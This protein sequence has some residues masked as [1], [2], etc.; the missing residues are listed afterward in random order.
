MTHLS[1]GLTLIVLPRPG[2]PFA[3]MVLGF[4]AEPA[5]ADAPGARIAVMFARRQRGGLS[6]LERGVLESIS[7][8]SDSYREHMS[9][10]S[11]EIEQA[12][13]LVEDQT[14]TMYLKWPSSA[15]ERWGARDAILEGT[16]E[17]RAWRSFEEA[18]WGSHPYGSWPRAESALRVT[19]S[20]AEAWLDRVYRPRNGVLVVVGNVD[21]AEVARRAEKKLDGWKDGKSAV[22][23]PPV[24]AAASR[25]AA[26]VARVEVTAANRSTTTIHFG[27]L[28]PPVVATRDTV[29][30]RLFS[31]L[32]DRDMFH[33]LRIEQGESYSPSVKAIF[34]RGGTAWM[35]GELDVAPGAASRA[36]DVVHAWLDVA[37]PVPYDEIAVERTRWR[38]ARRSNLRYD[39][40]EKMARLLFDTW[41]M[42]WEP[43]SLDGYPQ[44]LARVGA[45][46]LNRALAACRASAVVSLVGLAPAL[47]PSNGPR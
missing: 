3:S 14:D 24:P 44:A 4:H 43:A 28:L 37:A 38:L 9:L 17:Q 19:E 41:N 42:G 32:V 40:N 16:E 12:L 6:A 23:A 30:N 10:F 29:V 15:F 34:L 31:E 46:D 1:N 20:Q 39:T 26:S 13:S 36:L 45:A 33:R 5:P 47:S 25:P 27:C 7:R 2:L 8:D 11:D 22:P 35:H 18:L 21:A